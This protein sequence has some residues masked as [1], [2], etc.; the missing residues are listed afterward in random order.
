MSNDQSVMSNSLFSRVHDRQKRICLQG[1]SADQSAIHVRLIH[2]ALRVLRFHAS[3]VLDSYGLREITVP[4]SR[5]R[6]A[7]EVM[8]FLG[9]IVGRVAA[10]ADRPYRLVC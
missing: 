2:Q 3:A 9:L 7:D 1:R 10:G 4:L 8:D 6:L 5:D